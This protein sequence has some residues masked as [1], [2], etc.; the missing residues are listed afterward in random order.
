M[1]NITQID[2]FAANAPE[3][4]KWFEPMME[5]KPEIPIPYRHAFADNWAKILPHYNDDGD[6]WAPDAAKHLTSDQIKHFVDYRLKQ[7]EAF[8]QKDLWEK[9]YAFEKFFQ[10]RLYYAKEMSERIAKKEF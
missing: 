3:A 10:W 6:F 8:T 4:P 7:D 9:A 1:D 5:P 2:F